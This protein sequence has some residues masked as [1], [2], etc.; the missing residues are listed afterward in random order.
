MDPRS[1]AHE[2]HSSVRDQRA[3]PIACS[4][5]AK[6][7]AHCTI[8]GASERPCVQNE[9]RDRASLAQLQRAAVCNLHETASQ[10]VASLRVRHWRLCPWGGLLFLDC[11]HPG[12]A[13][14][15]GANGGE[16][17]SGVPVNAPFG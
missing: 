10:A 6:K 8:L 11:N 17:F 13:F 15:G 9:D 5:Q 4:L 14:F 3:S 7:K 1:R 2:E 16:F 12:P